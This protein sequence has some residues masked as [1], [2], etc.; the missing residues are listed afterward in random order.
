MGIGLVLGAAAGLIVQNMSGMEASW[1]KPVGDL[2]IRLIRMIVVPLVFCSIVS[3]AASMGNASK[4]GG[5][6]VRCLVYFTLTTAVAVVIGLAVANVMHPGA[7]VPL[8]SDLAEVKTVIQ[9]SL[10][11]TL[12]DIVPLNPF[13]AMSSGNLLQV[14]FFAIFLGFMLSAIGDKARTADKDVTSFAVPLGNTVNM[15][16]AALYLGIAAVFV[17][18][19]YG[20]PLSFDQ[21]ITV[22]IMSLLASVGSVGVPGSAL[23]VMTMVFCPWRGSALSPAWTAS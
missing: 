5:I 2:F 17:A 13:G 3:G 18:E 22:L 12:L 16:G 8:P 7:G 9:P 15:D 10:S 20:M 23:I 1:F 4:L 19:V 14:L 11:Q 6:A 21:Q